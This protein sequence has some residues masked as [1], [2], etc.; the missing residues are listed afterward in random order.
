M[1]AFDSEDDSGAGDVG[2]LEL[3]RDRK[4]RPFAATRYVESSPKFS[5]DGRWIAY[6][7]NE[8]GRNEIYAQAYPGPGPKL[9]ISIGGGTDPVWAGN[10]KEMFY[11]NGDNMMAVEVRLQ[12]SLMP[13]K[14]RVL[15]TGRYARGLSSGN[16]NP[17]N[18]NYDVTPDGQRFL[19]IQE[20]EDGLTA[21][22]IHVLPNWSAGLKG[23]LQ[24]EHAH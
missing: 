8:S 12:P 17:T 16:G 10:G 24:Q 15:W 2:V 9:Q 20:D 13:G 6:N 23:Q 1:I 7:S 5:P 11:R 3:D 19:M 18:S 4:P 21:T 22:Q 14:P